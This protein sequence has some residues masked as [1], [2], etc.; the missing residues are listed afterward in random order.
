MCFVMLCFLAV[1]DVCG[2]KFGEATSFVLKYGIKLSDL[3]SRRLQES[4]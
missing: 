2:S 1:G 4:R 3:W